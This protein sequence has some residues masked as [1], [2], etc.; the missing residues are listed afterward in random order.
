MQD[1]RED[2]SFHATLRVSIGGVQILISSQLNNSIKLL[3]VNILIF[4]HVDAVAT[5]P[6]Q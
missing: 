3:K 1:P 4:G 2:V 6:A 5:L